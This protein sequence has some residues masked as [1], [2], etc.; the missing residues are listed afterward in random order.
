MAKF[1]ANCTGELVDLID[2]RWE[3]TALYRSAC[4]RDVSMISDYGISSPSPTRL[5]AAHGRIR[6]EERASA[7]LFQFWMLDENGMKIVNELSVLLTNSRSPSS[8]RM[9]LRKTE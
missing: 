8:I 4:T 6:C 5:S 3:T 1:L 7:P 2:I 9:S